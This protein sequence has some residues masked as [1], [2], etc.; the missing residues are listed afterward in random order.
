ML[1]AALRHGRVMGCEVWLLAA[2]TA[3][4]LTSGAA[5]AA[6]LQGMQRAAAVAVLHACMHACGA[7]AGKVRRACMQLLG[8]LA[9]HGQA[10]MHIASGLPGAPHPPAAAAG[11]S[12]QRSATRSSPLPPGPGT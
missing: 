3:C 5:A 6:A 9:L 11:R 7:A 2:T 4:M 10:C 1:R 12:Q 8:Y